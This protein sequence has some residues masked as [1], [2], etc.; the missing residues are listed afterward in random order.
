MAEPTTISEPPHSSSSLDK[1]AGYHR[2]LGTNKTIG[3][4]SKDACHRN[5]YPATYNNGA[6]ETMPEKELSNPMLFK[7]N[8]VAICGMA[9][10]LPG[11]IS[12]DVDFWR[13]LMSKRDARIKV[14]TDRYNIDAFHNKAA[15]SYVI[16]PQHGYFL[17]HIDLTR[18][19]E[20]FFSMTRSEVEQLD[21][22]HRLLLE[23]TR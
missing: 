20:S 6:P 15:K 3:I 19:D 13:L 1:D 2:A 16:Q 4:I 14:P 21:P 18:F 22:Q 8:L 5:G 11:G 10:R 17:D 7:Q 23:L 12:S 9:M